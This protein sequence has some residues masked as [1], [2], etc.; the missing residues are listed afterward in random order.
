M[1]PQVAGEA[2]ARKACAN[3][4]F[5][6]T[7]RTTIANRPAGSSRTADPSAGQAFA[8]LRFLHQPLAAVGLLAIDPAAWPLYLTVLL[9]LTVEWPLHLQLAE[10]IEVYPPAE[11]TSASAAYLLGLAFLPIFW[12]STAL[13]FAIIVLLDGSGVVRASGIAADSV[14]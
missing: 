1:A 13:G 14:R 8:W 7:P 2:P 3:R 4:T 12:L 9:V 11:W 10:G 6:L 5:S